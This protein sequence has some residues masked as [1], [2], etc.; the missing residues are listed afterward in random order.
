MMPE[1]LLNEIAQNPEDKK[2]LIGEMLLYR[3]KYYNP[4]DV[5]ITAVGISSEE[6]ET[7][8]RKLLPIIQ[9]P[10][11]KTFIPKDKDELSY[12][13]QWTG[14][15]THKIEQA[16]K[17]FTSYKDNVSQNYVAI[18]WEAPSYNSQNRYTAHV[19]RALLGGGASF[20]SGGPG[21]GITSKLYTDVLGAGVYGL[22]LELSKALVRN[23]K[24][25]LI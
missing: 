9:N 4:N 2:K 22:N 19:L 12:V 8:V 18:G 14:G 17:G 5:S 1:D 15:I 7:V 21:K 16:Q 20:S 23:L 11:W 24:L 10:S 3:Q 13:S 6:L 25:L